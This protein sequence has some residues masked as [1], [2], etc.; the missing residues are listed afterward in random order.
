[1]RFIALS[2]LLLAAPNMIAAEQPSADANKGLDRN[3][4]NYVICRRESVTG[5]LAQSK[6]IC[7]TRADWAARSRGSQDQAQQMQSQGQIN[8]CASQ[9][10]GSC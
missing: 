9:T 7:M 3:D 2:V 5:S 10:L 1:M 6:K 4:P 8:S